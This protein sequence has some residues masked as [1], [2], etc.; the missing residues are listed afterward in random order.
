MPVKLNILERSDWTHKMTNKSV[1]R[2]EYYK[3]E[4]H[5]Y[6][7]VTTHNPQLATTG[8]HSQV[9]KRLGALTMAYSIAQG[10]PLH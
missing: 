5:F 9:P 2:Y 4:E 3:Q 6:L 7:D 8:N 10:E 1:D